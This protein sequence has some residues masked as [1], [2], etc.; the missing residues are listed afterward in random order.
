VLTGKA[1]TNNIVDG[2]VP[3][4]LRDDATAAEP[5]TVLEIRVVTPAN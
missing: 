5:K 1:A 3:L 4:G 2:M